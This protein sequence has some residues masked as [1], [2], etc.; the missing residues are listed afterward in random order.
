M[1]PLRERIPLAPSLAPYHSA[2]AWGVG[3]AL[4][5]S[6]Q[7]NTAVSTP[8]TAPNTPALTESQC[9]QAPRT[10][11]KLAQML[12]QK[13]HENKEVPLDANHAVQC[14]GLETTTPLVVNQKGREQF[15]RIIVNSKTE[16][17]RAVRISRPDKVVEADPGKTPDVTSLTRSAVVKIS[18]TGI[19]GATIK[20]SDGSSRPASVGHTATIG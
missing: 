10:G 8:A 17:M 12:T 19:P 7:P 2:L 3:I 13:L 6:A 20:L 1:K 9:S 18:P 14:N 16:A 4:A 11:D 5:F 15:F